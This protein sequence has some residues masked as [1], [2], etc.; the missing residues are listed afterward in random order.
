VPGL[1]L[2][3]VVGEFENHP[4]M[5]VD[6]IA[7]LCRGTDPVKGHAVHRMLHDNP[8]NIFN[9][10]WQPIIDKRGRMAC[11]TVCKDGAESLWGGMPRTTSSGTTT[12]RCVPG[13]GCSAAIKSRSARR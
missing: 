6:L 1:E 5:E 10:N 11:G 7:D 8:E 3:V 4:G 13:P 12:S 9:E 2:V